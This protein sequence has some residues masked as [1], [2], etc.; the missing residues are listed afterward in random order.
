MLYSEDNG[1][2]VPALHIVRSISQRLRQ[3]TLRRKDFVLALSFRGVMAIW[4]YYDDSELRGQRVLEQSHLPHGSN[5]K[6]TK[7]ALVSMPAGACFFPPGPTFCSSP[8]I[9]RAQKVHTHQWR[10]PLLK[11]K[12]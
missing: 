9:P 7:Q 4:L 1:G 5:K 10:S 3:T 12:P 8:Y 2:M 6:G 11:P